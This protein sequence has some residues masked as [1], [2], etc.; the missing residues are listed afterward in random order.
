ML[1]ALCVLV[2][3]G[4]GLLLGGVLIFFRLCLV[5]LEK[6]LGSSID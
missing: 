4:L 1:F 3:F 6:S 5:L 2:G